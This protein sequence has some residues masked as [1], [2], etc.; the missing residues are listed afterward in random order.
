MESTALNRD[1]L[2]QAAINPLHSFMLQ[3]STAFNHAAWYPLHSIGMFWDMLPKIHS[4]KS[5]WFGPCCKKFTAFIHAAGIHCIQSCCIKSTAFIRVPFLPAAWI[6]R[7]SITL[8][9]IYCIQSGWFG[10]CCI[11]STA[12]NHAAW[13]SLHSIGIQCAKMHGIHCIKRDP[14]SHAAWNTL[15]SIGMHL[16][17]LH[18]IHCI[19]WCRMEPLH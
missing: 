11:K 12:F 16:T 8:H 4:I 7:H 13:N 5:G 18:R 17:M 3:E 9:G 14:L 2:G 6:T 10:P 19:Q 15:G 1:A